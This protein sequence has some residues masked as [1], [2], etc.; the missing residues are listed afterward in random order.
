ARAAIPVTF[1]VDPT[2]ASAEAA[3]RLYRDGGHEVLVLANGIDANAS[4]KDLEVNFAGYFST[5][6]EAVGLMDTAG[7]GFERNRTLS[8]RI[9]AILKPEGYGMVTYDRGLNAAAQVAAALKIPSVEIA[10]SLRTPHGPDALNHTLDRL[11]FRAVQQGGLVVAAP[12]SQAII[13][14]LQNWAMGS[15]HGRDVTFAPVS[16]L[17]T[18]P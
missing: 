7:S 15:D 11:A 8:Q 4:P 10:A 1:A 13:T 9:G 18:N 14:A 6:K 2:T 17:F 3:A 5:V 12:A 16:A